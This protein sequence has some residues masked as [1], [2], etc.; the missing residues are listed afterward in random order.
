MEE[1]SEWSIIFGSNL[2][3]RCVCECVVFGSTCLQLSIFSYLQAF[4]NYSIEKEEKKTRI[5]LAPS[6]SLKCTKNSDVVVFSFHY[7]FRCLNDVFLIQY[8]CYYAYNLKFLSFFF[9]QIIETSCV[10]VFVCA[11]AR[12]V[13]FILT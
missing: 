11:R 5:S 13:S 12:N 1:C 2:S 10:C 6:L 7:L 9:I 8:L 4:M 3:L